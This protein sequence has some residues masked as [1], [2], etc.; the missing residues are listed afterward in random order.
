MQGVEKAA[1]GSDMSHGAQHCASGF[2]HICKAAMKKW[3]L[4]I[5]LM[6]RN[7]AQF[8]ESSLPSGS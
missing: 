2:N 4:L 7:P 1:C 5:Q 6:H 8:S 3:H